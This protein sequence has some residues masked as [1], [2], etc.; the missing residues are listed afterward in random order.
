MGLYHREINISRGCFEVSE[1]VRKT[2]DV[3]KS[4]LF[5]EAK[6]IYGPF[7]ELFAESEAD[8][9]HGLDSND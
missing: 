2:R 5:P 4:T 8:T 6:L 7:S 9:R 3:D 1:T